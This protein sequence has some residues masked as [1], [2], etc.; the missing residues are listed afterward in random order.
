VEAI[1]AIA[2]D[3]SCRSTAYA[4]TLRVDARVVRPQTLG[5]MDDLYRLLEPQVGSEGRSGDPD[6]LNEKRAS[7]ADAAIE[8]F[9]R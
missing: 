1:V 5:T 4:D 7:W 8:A 6:N 3:P 9:Q 2:F